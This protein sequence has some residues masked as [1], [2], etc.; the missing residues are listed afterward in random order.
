MAARKLVLAADGAGDDVAR[1]RAGIST[2]SRVST[3]GLARLGARYTGLLTT[4]P[5]CRVGAAGGAFVRAWATVFA[6]VAGSVAIMRAVGECFGTL[7]RA[8]WVLVLDLSCLRIDQAAPVAWTLALMS[9]WKIGVA[10]AFALVQLAGRIDVAGELDFVQ[11]T[12][13]GLLHLD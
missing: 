2:R 11:A 8:A 7:S 4:A 12:W 6:F 13:R 1:D 10:W 5:A 9:A 3:A